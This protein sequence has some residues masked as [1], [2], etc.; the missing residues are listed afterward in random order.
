MNLRKLREA[1]GLFLERYPDGFDDEEMAAIRKK[2]NVDKL[3][4]FATDALKKSSFVNQGTVLDDITKIVTRSSMI[5][6]FEKPKYRDFVGG[7]NRGDR[8]FLANAYRKLLHGAQKTG[9]D[10]V[11]DVL[12]E[13][14]LAKWSLMTIIPYQYRPKKDVF[15]KPTTTK[16]VIRQFELEGLEYKPR[17]SWAFYKRYRDAI[18]AM[19]EHCSPALSPNNAAFTGFLMMTTAVD[20]PG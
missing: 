3:S 13:A 15:V 19:K 1:E 2:H 12:T 6:M 8:E 11:L 9:F 7:L 10:E 18:T 14:K 17:P 5:S 4:E 20:Q 16:N